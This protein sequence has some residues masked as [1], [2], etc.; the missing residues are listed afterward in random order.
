MNSVA[1]SR[2]PAMTA[3][4]SRSHVSPDYA[5]TRV[6]GVLTLTITREARRNAITGDVLAGIA[7]CFTDAE[8]DRCG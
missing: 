5:I 4:V 7:Q 8:T 6:D 3:S 2:E 1:K